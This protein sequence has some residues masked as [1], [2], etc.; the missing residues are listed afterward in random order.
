MATNCCTTDAPRISQ[1][2]HSEWMKNLPEYLHNEPITKLA[3]PGRHILRNQSKLMLIICLGTHDSFAFH[4]TS[5]PGP[6]LIPTL[7][8]LHFFIHPIIKNW[9]ITQNKTFTGNQISFE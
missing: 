6:D 1:S 7:R 4:L 3:I 5:Q 9:S 8:R 2:K